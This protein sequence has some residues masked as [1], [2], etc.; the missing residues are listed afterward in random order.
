MLSMGVEVP[1]QLLDAA[2]RWAWSNFGKSG[3]R[4]AVAGRT[5]ARTAGSMLSRN[6][7]CL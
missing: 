5:S 6:S 4:N 2:E 3:T 7:P 1:D